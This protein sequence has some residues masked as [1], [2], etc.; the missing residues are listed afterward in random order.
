MKKRKW[1][2]E[3]MEDYVMVYEEG[4]EADLMQIFSAGTKSGTLKEAVKIANK[5][6]DAHN[7]EAI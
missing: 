6:V 1:D 3:I 4:Q 5:I 2:L 7:T